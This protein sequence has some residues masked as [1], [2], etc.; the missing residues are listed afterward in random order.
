MA[1][2]ELDLAA[3]REEIAREILRVHEEAYGTGAEQIEVHLVGDVVL[4]MIDVELSTAER[5]LISADRGDAVKA[6]R[7]TFQAAVAP[8]FKAIAERATGRT[9]VGFISHMNLDPPFEIELF[10]LKPRN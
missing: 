8:T 7:E 2:G 9:V 10:R 5:T 1:E 4:V 3:A 6:T